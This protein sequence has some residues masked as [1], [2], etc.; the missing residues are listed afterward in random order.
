MNKNK[1]FNILV[2]ENSQRYMGIVYDWSTPLRSRFQ[3]EYREAL[4][5]AITIC[6]DDLFKTQNAYSAL[7]FTFQHERIFVFAELIDTKIRIDIYDCYAVTNKK[8]T[9]IECMNHCKKFMMTLDSKDDGYKA[10]AATFY[11][12]NE[13]LSIVTKVTQSLIYDTL[14][15]KE[16][17]V[18]TS[19]A[20]NKSFK[21][22]I[23]SGVAGMEFIVSFS[24][25][26]H[27]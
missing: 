8:W 26:I 18:S 5:L 24:D 7:D 17:D 9:I 22:H 1:D 14:K 12:K 13:T 2:I 11:L 6:I 4:A 19:P 10:F 15:A 27:L 16:Y 23:H 3:S 21:R 20:M 25:A